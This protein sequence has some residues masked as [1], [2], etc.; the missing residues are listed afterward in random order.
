MGDLYT[1]MEPFSN[2]DI[3]RKLMGRGIA[4]S[5][6]MSVSF[7]LFGA[8]DR[9]VLRKTGGYLRYPV[10]ANGLDSV[11]QSLDYAIRGYDGILHV[12]SFGCTPELSAIP[13]LTNIGRDYGI[14]ILHLSF[15]THLSE[16]GMETRL[17]AFMDMIEMR[18]GREGNGLQSG[19]RRG[20][21]L[22][23]RRRS[24]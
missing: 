15:D 11:A 8:P 7:L 19:S 4:V 18:R 21:H 1:L 22:H 12:K 6:K 9:L 3:E 20:L 23:E 17:E 5:R 14:P 16:T 24:G 2:Y 13:A 10:G